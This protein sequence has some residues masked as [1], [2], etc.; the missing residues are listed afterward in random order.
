MSYHLQ[1]EIFEGPF[2]LLL[3]LVEKRKLF[4]NDVTLASITDEY[5]SCIQQI[6]HSTLEDMSMFITVCSTLIL[7]KSKSLFPKLELSKGEEQDIETLKKR[8][9]QYKIMQEATD[10]LKEHMDKGMKTSRGNMY[11]E[12]RIIFSPH[13]TLSLSNIT[14]ALRSIIERF[15]KELEKK[16]HV[17][18]R[19][20]M[21]L[22]D[23][24]NDLHS[25]ITKSG[26][27]NFS[28]FS[29]IK[30]GEKHEKEHRHNQVVSFLALLELVRVGI[31]SVSQ[32]NLFEDIRLETIE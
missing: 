16:K 28:S 1:T 14:T 21:S 32:N 4:I 10:I 26:V 8:L 5:L 29:E 20:V 24:M 3:D 19:K 13:A 18:L 12:E 6:E 22:E 17:V 7:I 23:M 27:M 9:F 31:L 15:P 2:A 11:K 25:R 30:R